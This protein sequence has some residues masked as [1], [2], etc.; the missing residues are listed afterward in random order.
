MQYI[1]SSLYDRL[2]RNEAYRE[3]DEMYSYVINW[4]FLDVL[5]A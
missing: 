1:I 4:P 2:Q 3:V 5:T